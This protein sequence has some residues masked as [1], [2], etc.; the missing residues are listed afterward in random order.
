L[1]GDVAFAQRMANKSDAV[2]YFKKEN[3]VQKKK[4]RTLHFG[5]P[6]LLYTQ[7]S[8]TKTVA[9]THT[10][11]I[12]DGI[13][14]KTEYGAFI[15]DKQSRAVSK[16]VEK[17]SGFYGGVLNKIDANQIPSKQN[18]AMEFFWSLSNDSM[19]GNKLNAYLRST[20]FFSGLDQVK[21]KVAT[22]EIVTNRRGNDKDKSV[23]LGYV[24]S[25]LRA[26]IDANGVANLVQVANQ[27]SNIFDRIAQAEIAQFFTNQ[28]NVNWYCAIVDR[29]DQR[30]VLGTVAEQI[31][32]CRAYVEHQTAKALGKIKKSLKE[33]DQKVASGENVSKEFSELGQE[34][35]KNRFLIRTFLTI[36]GG[37]NSVNFEL[38]GERLSQINSVEKFQ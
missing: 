2:S 22:K 10:M 7:S 28:A 24:E 34:V 31:E 9:K 35:T 5:L 23:K 21:H 12:Q 13:E 14:L 26:R 25:E 37:N 32:K 4:V 8:K 36:S 27:R 16:H 17:A 38:K 6:I 19:T 15:K 1:Q 29:P 11:M 33:I 3:G 18:I 20:A 30:H